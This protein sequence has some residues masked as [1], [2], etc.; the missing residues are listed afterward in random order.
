[1]DVVFLL[2]IFFMLSFGSPMQGSYINLP[3]ATEGQELSLKALSILITS[4]E[5]TLEGAPVA[6]EALEELP[7]PQD[8]IILAER[9]VPYFRVMHVLDVLKSSGH[10]RV[11][12][13]TK[14]V[15]R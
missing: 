12:L 11:S 5:I 13:A 4:T 14:P 8:I 6:L 7:V 1:M 9:E 15:I 3:E 10:E 2:L